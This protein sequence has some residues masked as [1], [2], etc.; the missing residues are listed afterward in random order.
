MRSDFFTD[1]LLAKLDDTPGLEAL[2][3]TLTESRKRGFDYVDD[4]EALEHFDSEIAEFK[5]AFAEDDDDHTV[6]EAADVQ[7]LLVELARRRN[8]KLSVQTRENVRK[9]LR[10]LQFVEQTLK[11]R[12][13][14]WADVKWPDDIKPIWAEAKK[15][16]L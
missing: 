13:Q 15:A 6:D 10:R 11:R 9:F 2:E 8:R 4:T 1:K 5:E 14:T 7:F 3:E 16:G 12:G